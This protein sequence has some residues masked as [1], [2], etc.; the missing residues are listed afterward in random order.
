MWVNNVTR[1]FRFLA[2]YNIMFSVMYNAMWNAVVGEELQ[3]TKKLRIQ[4][5]DMQSPSYK[6]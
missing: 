5:T 4:S 6:V 1:V 2:C 3:C